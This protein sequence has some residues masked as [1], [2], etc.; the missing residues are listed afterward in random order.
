MDKFK[1]IFLRFIRV[2]VFSALATMATITFQQ[3]VEWHDV[4]SILNNLLIAGVVGGI[5][6]VVAGADKWL[7]WEE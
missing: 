4:I 3:A 6:G 2:F 5:S 7:R 1:V